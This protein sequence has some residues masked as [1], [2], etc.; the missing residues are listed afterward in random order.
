ML[1]QRIGHTLLVTA[2]LAVSLAAVAVSPALA[3]R[4][5]EYKVFEHCPLATKHLEACLVSRT[6]S[7][8][9]TIG[10]QEV[11][12]ISTQT[13]QGGFTENSKEELS[14]V[15]AEGGETFS[16]TPQK[17]PGGLLGIKCKEIKGEFL[18]EKGLRATCEY[19]FEHGLTEVK[20][21]TELAKPASSI[22]LS[23]DNLLLESGTALSLPVKV[24]L[25]NTLFGSECYIGS[26]KEPIT[27]NL[28]SGTSGSLKGRVGLPTTR[29][30]GGILVISFN[31]L[32]DS[33]FSAPKATGCGFGLLDGI[34]NEKI[35]LPAS[36]T[37]TATLNNTIE[38]ATASVVKHH[39]EEEEGK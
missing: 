3:E 19:L 8:A 31:T 23:E 2:A 15:G 21:R 6:E 7:G 13:L 39:F 27:L 35:G 37:D 26:E 32:V 12:I 30:E 36:T 25:E 20:A 38:Q 18:I 14:F 29:A 10:K 17:V 16:K 28:T 33:G 9:I 5:G 24:K 11:P 1:K 34:I 4:T 22:G